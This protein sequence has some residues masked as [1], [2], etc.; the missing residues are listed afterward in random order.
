MSEKESLRLFLAEGPLSVQHAS[1]RSG[2]SRVEIF[3][4]KKL[5]IAEKV[6]R[7]VRTAY[8]WRQLSQHSV[9]ARRGFIY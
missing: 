5:I 1:I 6:S 2:G 9:N 4:A 7:A 8:C 3:H